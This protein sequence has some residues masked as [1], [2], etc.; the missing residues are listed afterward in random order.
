MVHRG[1]V[2]KGVKVLLRNLREVFYP[3]TA[4]NLQDGASAKIKDL[5]RACAMFGINSLVTLTSTEKSRRSLSRQLREVHEDGEGSDLHVPRAQVQHQRVGPADDSDIHALLPRSKD[6]DIRHL[7]S[8]LVILNG[9]GATDAPREVQ[10]D[11]GQKEWTTGPE[12]RRLAATMFNNL[13][14]SLNLNRVKPSNLKRA[15]LVN[16]DAAKD[17]AEVRHY[18]IKQTYTDMNNKLKKILNNNRLP[19]LAGV[20]DLSQYFTGNAGVL[21]DSDI[22]QLPNSKVDVE[23]TGRSGKLEKRKV[24]LRL[25]EVGPRLTLRLVK[26]EEGFHGG[27]VYYHRYLKKSHREVRELK[28][29]LSSKETLKQQRRDEQEARVQDKQERAQELT[30]K[31]NAKVQRNQRLL[32]ALAKRDPND[33]G[34]LDEAELQRLDA[35]ADGDYDDEA[36]GDAADAA[37]DSEADGD[38]FGDVDYSDADAH[39]QQGDMD[40]G[41]ED[42]DQDE[43]DLDEDDEGEEEADWDDIDKLET[44]FV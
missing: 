25:F 44:D 42:L 23:E 3:Y 18:F 28:A 9:F 20:K 13:F 27:E 10:R 34:E 4:M 35:I 21:S 32:E 11:N 41:E 36:E 1:H 14:P 2:N 31:L 33:L 38:E 17:L 26:I 7:G 5:K 6:V 12:E 8:P 39:S 19:N 37:G 24:N 29:A 30:D 43:D 16:Y 22:D 40:G 15:V